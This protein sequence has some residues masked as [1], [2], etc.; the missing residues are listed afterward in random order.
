MHCVNCNVWWRRN[1]VFSWFWLGPL[2][3]VK[4]NINTTAY[5]NILDDSVFPTLWEQ[6]REGAFLYQHDRAHV[7]KVRSIQKGFVEICVAELDWP[8]Q[9][10]DLNPIQHLWDDLERR[11]RARPNRPISVPNLTIALVAE[12]KQVPA[13]MFQHLVHSLPRRVGAVIAAKGGQTQY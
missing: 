1:N 5:N 4:G 10:H 13:A 7:F 8:A 3:P 11:L 2:V 9:I 12:W 6:F